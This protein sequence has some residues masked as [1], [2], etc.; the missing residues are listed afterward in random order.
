MS[1][2]TFANF[3][4]VREFLVGYMP[5]PGT[6][7]QAYT[8][9]R[10][11][12]LME[13]LG[14]PQDS[15]KV[16]HVAGTSGKT[17]T[18]YY[19]AG[20]LRQAGC[21][22]GLTVSPHIDEINERVQ[23]DMIPLAEAEYCDLFG[24]FIDAISRTSAKPTYFELLVAFAY[25]VFASKKVDYAVV[26][27]GLGGLLDA[28]NVVNRSDKL[29]IVTD[30]GL[31]HMEILGRTVAA[32]AA[33]K[34]G[35]IRPSNHVYMYEQGDEVMSVV[36]DVCD[37]NQA[38]LHEVVKMPAKDLPNNMP[39]F[40][41]RNWYLVWS[42]YQF[43]MKRDNLDDLTEAQLA[44]STAVYVPARME[45][46]SLKSG[47][48]L[49]LDGAHNAQKMAVFIKSLRARFP[50]QQV[51]VLMSLN[52]NKDFQLK[53]CLEE[54]TSIANHLI[55]TSFGADQDMHHE[56]IK[57]L[58]IAQTCHVIG[59]DDWETISN[60]QEAYKALLN[61]PEPILLITG[62][63]YLL[64]YIRPLIQASPKP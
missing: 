11:Q 13:L 32:V 61:R 45:I 34:A 19:M 56:S 6:M 55:I 26:E 57:P 9:E 15:Y 37:Q 64:N 14:N 40:Q 42:T 38:T 22:V 2:A 4:E 5:K 7:R 18:A 54:I 46:I 31:D 28:T 51:S 12:L 52:K 8:L 17:S 25:W 53:P 50:G 3:G 59:Y 27:V 20:M 60:S 21:T 16:V 1:S 48:T 43:L 41:R 30:I 63:F 33:Q 58:K 10:M 35:I 39:L 29:C 62:S 23:I 24:K 49:V 44:A 36:R 47:Q